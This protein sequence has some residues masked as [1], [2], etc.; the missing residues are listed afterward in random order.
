M[1]VQAWRKVRRIVAYQLSMSR[2]FAS[3]VLLLT[4]SPARAID[5][6]P[7]AH[8]DRYAIQVGWSS[9][10]DDFLGLTQLSFYESSA[11]RFY[12]A[13]QLGLITSRAGTLAGAL[14]LGALNRVQECYCLAQVGGYNRSHA[15]T[16]LS[17]LGLVNISER[18]FVGLLQ[19]ALVN[20]HDE[21]VHTDFAGAL[22]IGLL[23]VHQ[24]E[25]FGG[26]Q[27][28]LLNINFGRSDVILAL[29]QLGLINYSAAITAPWQLGLVNVAGHLTGA[30]VSLAFNWS[31]RSVDGVQLGFSNRAAVIRGAQVALGGNIAN[32]VHGL[33]IGVVNSTARLHGVQIGLVNISGQGGLPFSVIANVGW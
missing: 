31:S 1:Q 8:G 3:L 24:G 19:L 11:R 21:P 32:S 13:L 7:L 5:P 25:L 33:Q 18:Q 22:Q 26:A 4:G 17:Q 30:Q 10:A 15:F 16:G 12:G 14:Q 9:R 28:G 23:N 2:V 27:I 20:I 6:P 29:G